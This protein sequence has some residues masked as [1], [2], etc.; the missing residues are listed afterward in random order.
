MSPG[1]TLSAF[2]MT[3]TLT[4]IAVLQLAERRE[5]D[6]DD[7]VSKYIEHPYGQE[8]SIRQLLN[9]TSG[10]PNRSP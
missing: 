8:I 5:I 6:I 10:I 4:A 9:H 7:R 2:S 1:H 3:K